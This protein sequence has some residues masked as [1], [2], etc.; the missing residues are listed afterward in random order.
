MQF[1][2]ALINVCADAGIDWVVDYFQCACAV[3]IQASY[4]TNERSV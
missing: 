4:V 3:G 1:K 2:D